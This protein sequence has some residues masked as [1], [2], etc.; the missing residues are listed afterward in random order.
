MSTR[1]QVDKV[2]HGM[3]RDG[4]N[5]PSSGFCQS[6][7]L[8]IVPNL[9]ALRR[10]DGLHAQ[11]MAHGCGLENPTLKV[12]EGYPLAVDHEARVELLGNKAA[13]CSQLLDL[14]GSSEAEQVINEFPDQGRTSTLSNRWPRPIQ[15]PTANRLIA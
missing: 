7:S 14:R 8:I 3:A 2:Y 1:F 5:P 11:E 12:C 13:A 15:M 6:V 4:R 9:P 10:E